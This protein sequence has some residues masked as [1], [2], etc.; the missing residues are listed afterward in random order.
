LDPPRII[1]DET[2]T[3]A[4][5]SQIID[6]EG[7]I[8][9][10]IIEDNGAVTAAGGCTR[11]GSVTTFEG[12]AKA[13][14]AGMSK[15][16]GIHNKTRHT[17]F[18]NPETRQI[19]VHAVHPSVF[20]DYYY[21]MDALDVAEWLFDVDNREEPIRYDDEPKAFAVGI[22]LGVMNAIERHL[23]GNSIDWVRCILAEALGDMQLAGGAVGVRDGPPAFT[24]EQ[25]RAALK[26][27]QETNAK[28]TQE[29]KAFSAAVN[30]AAQENRATEEEL[31]ARIAEIR[32]GR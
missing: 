14:P 3:H 29:V 16:F 5:Q 26:G 27:I 28:A 32:K 24:V 2:F 25:V 1:D 12:I 15:R 22:P 19:F 10:G 20:E 8:Y 31:R 7:N 30:D 23:D 17:M 6:A 13:E 9:H 4:L 11:Y 21:S 18:Y